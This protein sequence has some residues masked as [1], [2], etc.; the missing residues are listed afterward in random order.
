MGKTRRWPRIYLMIL[1]SWSDSTNVGTR[2]R[3]C[4]HQRGSVYTTP[5]A[6][7]HSGPAEPGLQLPVVQVVTQC[8]LPGIIERRSAPFTT[9]TQPSAASRT[10]GLTMP[11]IASVDD[12]PATIRCGVSVCVVG[13]RR[14]GS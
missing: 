4:R 14:C 2:G 6:E 10:R 8:A 1:A 9:R 5:F 13:I 7:F 3:E 11:R 12:A